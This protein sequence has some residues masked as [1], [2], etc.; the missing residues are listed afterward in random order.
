MSLPPPDPGPSSFAKHL[1]ARLAGPTV[2]LLI[3]L[4]LFG[5][6]L[7]SPDEVVSARNGDISQQFIGW[8]LF[9]F[10]EIANG[11][12]P[13]W[14]PYLFCG[15]SFVGNWQTAMFYPPNYL[16]LLLPMGQAMTA[17][18]ALHVYLGGLTLFA[19][20]RYR[21][22]S[23]L[24][25]VVGATAY[26][27]SAPILGH[28]Y[29]GHITWMCV[30]AWTPALF[31]AVDGYLD[32][33]RAKYLWIGSG[34]LAMQV[35]AGYPQPVYITL[36]GATLYVILNLTFDRLRALPGLAAMV[37]LGV[38]LSAI[39]FLPGVETGME[40]NRAGG[41]SWEYATHYSVPWENFL[42]TLAPSAMGG[43]G[44]SERDPNHYRGFGLLWEAWPYM[45]AAAVIL[46]VAAG[47]GT[48]LRSRRWA[49]TLAVLFTLLSTGGALYYYLIYRGLP[50]GASFRVPGRWLLLAAM[51][52]AILAAHGFDALRAGQRI[53]RLI[54]VALSA[55]GGACLIA[56]ATMK[57]SI[58]AKMQDPGPFL[59]PPMIASGCLLVAVAA[60]IAL[61][62]RWR[63]GACLLAA[64][65]I[66]EL[67]V[68]ARTMVPTSAA[69]LFIP[70][71]W[72]AAL[73]SLPKD[74]RI[75]VQGGGFMNLPLWVRIPGLS[76][77]DP[78]QSR[79]YVE[80]M[81]ATQ[82]QDPR[83]VP[84]IFGPLAP[85]AAWRLLR[86][87]LAINPNGQFGVLADGLPHAFL[88]DDFLA[89]EE[90]SSRLAALMSPAFDGRKLVLLDDKPNL[91]ET[92][93]NAPP[94]GSAR[95]LS[96]SGDALDIQVDAARPAVLVVTDAYARGW[97]ATRRDTGENLPV[98][99]ADHL[100]RGVPLP[101]GSYVVR[102]E[103]R[104]TGFIIGRWV[105]A[106]SLAAYLAWGAG[107]WLKGRGARF[108]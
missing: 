87:G 96:D 4:F 9:A 51:F 48:P 68:A 65:A 29:P 76:G 1:Y 50:G 24:A 11:H 23:R 102:M 40:S 14:N 25:S 75:Q 56:L 104:P 72:T 99:P 42:L 101:A 77:Y 5:R 74:G 91:P 73:Q 37:A 60:A 88:A 55:G 107:L 17:V 47:L 94:A 15:Q 54:A 18:I 82:G 84:E 61:V 36:V 32:T 10:D 100:L 49:G 2:L 44:M 46:A 97:V 28:A 90:R 38:A 69:Q 12:W 59:G 63:G 53:P 6:A 3:V 89:V 41:T 19:W 103:Y 22:A 70:A 85:S 26:M 45:G 67:A 31:L 106:G 105:S 52:G 62:G 39:Q 7:G 35:L 78:L 64:L 13:L 30:V 71:D 79:R 8:R 80:F 33:R 92:P 83:E 20:I 86:A 108:R 21:G 34:A 93:D 58:P 95:V 43:P 27:L 81:A 16:H 98:V 57:G 66:G